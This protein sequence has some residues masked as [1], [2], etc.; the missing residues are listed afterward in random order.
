MIDFARFAFWGKCYVRSSKV[1]KLPYSNLTIFVKS[2]P[3]VCV[4]KMP[5]I[6]LRSGELK[7]EYDKARAEML[8]A[9]EDTQFNYHKKRG[10]AAE[11]KE[12]KMEKD[13]AE[14]Y[15]KLKVQL[16]SVRGLNMYFHVNI[17]ACNVK[18]CYFKNC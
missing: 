18:V 1:T 11:K 8:K 12:A 9:E 15:Q 5:P 13:E 6:T 2:Q 10:I 14:R 17:F 3:L 4:N 16:V 7:E